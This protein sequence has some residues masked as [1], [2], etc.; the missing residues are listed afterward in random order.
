MRLSRRAIQRYAVALLFFGVIGLLLTDIGPTTSALAAGTLS[1]FAS[2]GNF[3]PVGI[4]ATPGRVLAVH[5]DSGVGHP[6]VLS[7]DTAGNA[8]TLATLLGAVCIDTSE[9]YITIAPAI[10]NPTS[11]GTYPGGIPV[12]PPPNPAGF[13]SNVAYVTNGYTVY[14]V[15]PNGSVAQFAAVPSCPSF[16]GIT[17]DRVGTFGYQLIAICTTG[18]VWLF[19]KNGGTVTAA[20]AATGNPIATVPITTGTAAEGPD[21]APLNTALPGLGGQLFVTVAKSGGGGKIYAVSPA[22]A[23]TAITSLSSAESVAFIP[24]PKCTYGL[25][26]TSPVYF[27]AAFGGNAVDSLSMAAFAGLNLGGNALIA[28]EGNGITLLNAVKGKIA[29]STFAA[30]GVTLQGSAF[31][32]CSTPLLL[33]S[34]R[35]D[36]GINAG[37]NGVVSVWILQTPTFNPLTI[38]VN[39]NA[40]NGQSCAGVYP[41]GQVTPPHYGVTGTENSFAGC[42][43]GL[44]STNQGPALLCKFTKSALG[45]TSNISPYNGPLIVNLFYIGGGGDGDAGGEN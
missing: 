12:F 2:I 21:V 22:G 18:Q 33:N 42:G 11:A 8:T 32:D 19:N 23:V 31:V 15:Q 6:V 14:Q 9:N 27:T 35:N 30:S 34:F 3:G 41:N 24:S 37:A 25:A 44:V 26:N 36:F 20:G 5:C 17:F 38:C 40:V 45:I 10:S 39:A 7:L 4:A 1:Q 28:T 16:G 13:T 29:T 43:T